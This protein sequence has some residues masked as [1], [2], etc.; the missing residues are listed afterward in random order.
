MISLLLVVALFQAPQSPPPAAPPTT[1]AA[2]VKAARDFIQSQQRALK[3]IT[4]DALRTIEADKVANAQKCAAQFNVATYPEAGL[5]DLIA[6]YGESA[7]P[8][9]AKAALD[10][11]LASKTLTATERGHVLAQAVMTGLREPKSPE[12]NA[13]LERYV[14]E[15]DQLEGDLLDAKISAH[16]RMNGYYRGDDIDDGIIKHSTWLMEQAKTFTPQQRALY[17][18]TIISAHINMAEAVAGRGDNPRAMAL[19]N[20]AKTGWSDIRNADRMIDPVLARYALVGT[21]AAPITAPRWLNAPANSTIAMPGAVTLLEFTAHWC[22]PC[23]ESYP[24]VKRLLAKYGPRGFRVVLATE[25][26]GYF[27]TERGLTP[28]AEFERDREYWTHEGLTVPI[29]VSDQRGLP[30]PGDGGVVAS[31]ENPNDAAYKVGGIPQ[32]H[33][34]DKN[35]VIRLIM[36]GYDDA[37]EASLARLIEKLLKER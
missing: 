6:L 26:Y 27:G 20:A 3:Q 34:I 2:C 10:R 33:I 30:V 5:A 8:A 19:L 14:D 16:A 21:P 12:R 9:L 11:A 35:G 1:P 25:L 29:A 31:V 18:G 32:I 7:Q 17:G 22:G 13:R 37:N 4:S 15:L 36:V 28:E 23:K 24:G